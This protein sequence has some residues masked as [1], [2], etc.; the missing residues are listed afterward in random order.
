MLCLSL[1]RLGLSGLDGL[2]LVGLNRRGLGH[3][4]LGLPRA[5]LSLVG[6]SHWLLWPRMALTLMAF[7]LGGVI[8]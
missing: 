5:G 7:G 2:D 1:V 4:G 6:L 3:G 8:P